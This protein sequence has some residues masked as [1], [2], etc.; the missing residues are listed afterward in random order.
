MPDSID[1]SLLDLQYRPDL[2][3]LTARWLRD[4]SLPELQQAHR[5]LQATAQ[6]HNAFH[7][8]MDRR[9]FSPNPEIAQWVAHEW[10]PDIART[11][12]SHLRLAS[13]VSP[14]LWHLIST[15]PDFQEAT[16]TA[17]NA[18]QPYSV[19]VFMDEGEAVR[20]LTSS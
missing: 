5:A 8:L 18:Q 14:E 11:A 7:W 13:L 1:R 4:A 15:Q 17:L 9:R 2:H 16:N 12:S 3:I 19:R 6:A 10:L 20:W